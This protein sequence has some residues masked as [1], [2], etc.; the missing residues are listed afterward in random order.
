M[1]SPTSLESYYE[2]YWRDERGPLGADP[3]AA[4]RVALLRSELAR[5]PAFAVLDAGCGAGNLVA[6]LAADGV[7]AVGMDISAHAVERAAAAH[8]GQRFVRHAVEE[9]PWPVAPESVDLVVAFEVIEHLLR[10][11]D[12][13][14][15]A[16]EALR[17]GGRLVLTTPFH[18][19]A[20]NVVL[21][22]TRFER[23]FAVE[24]D[25]IRF[26]T[27]R[28]LR[29]LLEDAGFGVE[30]ISHFGR[31]WPLWAGVFVAARKR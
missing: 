30:R 23:H 31:G 15:G 5:E 16:H 1:T 26:F 12:L 3:L 8:P 19:R 10:P 29:A 9:R 13:L 14:A 21:A 4:A 27:D 6:A 2:D 28:S 22:L 25:H 17:P 20:K 7:T 24:G 11:A 18:G